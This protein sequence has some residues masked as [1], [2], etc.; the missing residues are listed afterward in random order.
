VK[1]TLEDIENDYKSG[2][3]NWD[4]GKIFQAVSDI[5]GLVIIVK[6]LRKKLE[7]KENL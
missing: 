5:T 2:S 1:R 3:L 4:H 7:D 6:E